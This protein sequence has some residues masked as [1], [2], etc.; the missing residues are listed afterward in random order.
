MNEIIIFAEDPLQDNSTQEIFDVSLNKSFLGIF[1]NKLI[2]FIKFDHETN[3]VFKHIPI[4][5]ICI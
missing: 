4:L 5:R 3:K 2:I 1:G